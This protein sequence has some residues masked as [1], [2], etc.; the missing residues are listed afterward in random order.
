MALLLG[1]CAVF[2]VLS[3]FEAELRSRSSASVAGLASLPRW[4]GLVFALDPDLVD[5]VAV[6]PYGCAGLVGASASVVSVGV[7]QPLEVCGF[8]V[9]TRLWERVTDDVE[10]SIGTAGSG[11]VVFLRDGRV[12]AVAPGRVDVTAEYGSLSAFLKLQV[13]P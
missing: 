12:L 7:E 13:L 1:A 6:L 4:T 8:S 11:T 2:L 9:S 10:L 5:L 3:A